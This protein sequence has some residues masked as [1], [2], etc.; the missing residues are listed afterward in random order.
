MGRTGNTLLLK[1]KGNMR[2]EM[3]TLIG[4]TVKRTSE[5]NE[6]KST[7]FLI[8]PVATPKNSTQLPATADSK[9]TVLPKT[10]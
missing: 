7:F 9:A 1:G 4:K 3:F 5:Y 2:V 6:Y 10:S 8:L